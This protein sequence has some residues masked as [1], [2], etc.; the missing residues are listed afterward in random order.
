M[1]GRKRIYG[2][3]V[4]VLAAGAIS[5]AFLPNIW[6]LIGLRFIL[7]IGIGGRRSGSYRQ[8]PWD[9]R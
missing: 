1:L 7:G 6:W 4:L 5:C 9:W 2:A 3:E 8:R